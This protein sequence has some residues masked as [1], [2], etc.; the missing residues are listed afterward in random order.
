MGGREGQSRK[1][2][3]VGDRVAWSTPMCSWGQLLGMVP[4]FSAMLRC[5][6]HSNDGKCS[7]MIASPCSRFSCEVWF[8]EWQKVRRTKL[9]VRSDV[10]LRLHQRKG[11]KRQGQLSNSVSVL[12]L[13]ENWSRSYLICSSI[14]ALRQIEIESGC[15]R[16]LWNSF[17][18][19]GWFVNSSLLPREAI[20]SNFWNKREDHSIT[21]NEAR[22]SFHSLC[23]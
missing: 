20:K 17:N 13:V 15:S 8:L 3:K 2:I 18:I 11:L 6:H 12:M 23:L 1:M 16:K 9:T 22:G 4:S 19:S 21:R 5:P 10:W 7:K 14:C